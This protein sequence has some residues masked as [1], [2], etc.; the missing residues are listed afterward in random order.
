[1]SGS[2]PKKEGSAPPGGPLPFSGL[3]LQVRCLCSRPSRMVRWGETKTEAIGEF[4]RQ[5][6]LE[7]LISWGLSAYV[8]D[9]GRQAQT[10]GFVTPLLP[11]KALSMTRQIT[12]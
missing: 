1:M 8:W 6:P 12:D 5:N 9:K 2:L 10:A 7:T 3:R 4:S 11:R